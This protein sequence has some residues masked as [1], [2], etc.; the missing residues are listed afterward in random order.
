MVIP[1]YSCKTWVWRNKFGSACFFFMAWVTA[2]L[3]ALL[4]ISWVLLFQEFVSNTIFIHIYIY[5]IYSGTPGCILVCPLSLYLRYIGF[6]KK[7]FNFCQLLSNI[8]VPATLDL[9]N[10]FPTNRTYRSEFV[11]LRSICGIA[12][13]RT[14][15]STPR[16]YQPHPTPPNPCEDMLSRHDASVAL[17]ENVH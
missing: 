4:E 14:Q 9:G 11:N 8:C 17:Q 3:R 5:N 12:V 7:P 15:R 2:V 6:G 10:M 1:C 13:E 16:N